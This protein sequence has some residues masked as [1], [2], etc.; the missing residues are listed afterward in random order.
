MK[1]LGDS[2]RSRI[3][4]PS[5]DSFVHTTTEGFSRDTKVGSSR[6]RE[7]KRGAKRARMRKKER[8]RSKRERERER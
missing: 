5:P 8:K 6:R 3:I 1:S 2:R 7:E 4:D